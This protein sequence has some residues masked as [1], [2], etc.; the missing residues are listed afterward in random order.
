M[1]VIEKA[2][3]LVKSGG[4]IFIGDVQS[5]SLIELF[6]TSVQ[7]YQASDRL[8]VPD[9]RQRIRE[10]IAEEKRLLFSPIVFAALSQRFSQISHAEIQLKRGQHQNELTHFSLRCRAAY[11]QDFETTR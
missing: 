6:H 5:Y 4:Q 10:R 9:L 7:L 1:K 2:L 3:S 8:S 11:G